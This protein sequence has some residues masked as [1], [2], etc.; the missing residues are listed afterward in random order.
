[1]FHQP[2]PLGV[3]LPKKG[4]RKYLSPTTS[5]TS[6]TPWKTNMTMEPTIWRCIM[7]HL[8]SKF[9]IFHCHVSF[10]GGTHI[11]LIFRDILEYPGPGDHPILG[12]GTSSSKVP[13]W[14]GTIIFDISNCKSEGNTKMYMG[15]CEIPFWF[16]YDRTPCASPLRALAWMRVLSHSINN[17]QISWRTF[18]IAFTSIPSLSLEEV[19]L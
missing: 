8:I 19:L 2:G 9:V 4:R 6:F 12:K 13:W 11:A 18:F 17:L 1:M 16:W 7:M 10:Q 15:V 14:K 3:K 5:V